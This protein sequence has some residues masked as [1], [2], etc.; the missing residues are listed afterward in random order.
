MTEG[1]PVAK[2]DDNEEVTG[3][4]VI[5][6][7]RCVGLSAIINPLLAKSGCDEDDGGG[8]ASDEECDDTDG[9]E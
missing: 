1:D 2:L 9:A 6:V 8:G 7:G 5:T 4:R 3:P